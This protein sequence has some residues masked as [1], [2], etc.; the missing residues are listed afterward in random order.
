M[1]MPVLV[2]NAL[3]W[4]I[5]RLNLS[6]ETALLDASILLAHVLQRTRAYVMCYPKQA[7]SESDWIVF[8][9]L[10]QRCVAGEPIAY[11]RGYGEFW[12][13]TLELNPACLIPRPETELL[14]EKILAAY[15]AKA[16]IRLADLGTGSGAIALALASERPHW[17]IVATDSSSEALV[18][19]QNNAQRLG[20]TQVQFQAGDWC[21]AL[22][23]YPA[24]HIIVSNPPYLFAADSRLTQTGLAYEPRKALAA[25]TSGLEALHHI[26][27]QARYHLTA[28]GSLWLEQGYDQAPA[29]LQLLKQYGYS[30]IEQYTD[31]A[32]ILRVSKAE[33]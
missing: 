8:Q 26:I 29:V 3:K 10:I 6:V 5:Q 1:G 9:Q 7:I 11:L 16:N 21:E 18:M 27:Q 20:L 28:K 25:G 12:G 14:V 15:P 24:F 32:R 17:R 22:V 30:K 13:L 4:G 33:V 19:A 31:L 23:N 2:E